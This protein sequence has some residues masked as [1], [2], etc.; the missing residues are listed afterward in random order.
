MLIRVLKKSSK[1]PLFFAETSIKKSAKKKRCGVPDSRG[2]PDSH[3]VQKRF[4]G[5]VNIWA[6]KA[7]IMGCMKR[8][9]FVVNFLKN[10]CEVFSPMGHGLVLL[11]D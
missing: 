9:N 3:A 1:Q 2:F 11:I 7:A 4:G 8:S 5:K 10:R 6:K